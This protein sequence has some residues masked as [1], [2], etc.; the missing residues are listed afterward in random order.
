MLEVRAIRIGTVKVLTYASGLLF[1]PRGMG[2]SGEIDALGQRTDK[3]EEEEQEA[4]VDVGRGRRRRENDTGLGQAWL[5][6]NFVQ[7]QQ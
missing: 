3:E 5:R 4:D 6:L 2:Q 7:Q 1:R